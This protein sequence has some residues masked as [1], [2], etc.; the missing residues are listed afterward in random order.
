MQIAIKL[1]N[2][3]QRLGTHGGRQRQPG[4]EQSYRLK[5]HFHNSEETLPIKSV[6]LSVTARE[7]RMNALSLSSYFI[8]ISKNPERRGDVSSRVLTRCSLLRKQHTTGRRSNL[9]VLFYISLLINKYP[10]QN[11]LSSFSC[12]VLNYQ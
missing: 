5:T 8:F 12:Q 3:S 1:Q 6:T 4:L 9:L 2:L 7:A 11:L 10:F